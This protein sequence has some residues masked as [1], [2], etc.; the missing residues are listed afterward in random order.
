MNIYPFCSGGVLK[1]VIS[2]ASFLI[3]VYSSRFS[4]QKCFGNR[5]QCDENSRLWTRQRYQQYRLLQKDHQCKSMAVTQWAGAGVGLRMFQEER[6]SML[7]AGWDGWGPIP[8][9]RFPFF[10]LTI[11]KLSICKFSLYYVNFSKCE[12]LIYRIISNR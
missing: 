6:P 11:H 10:C 12:T 9:P 5:K 4:S 2:L 8:L 7:R 1:L 3:S